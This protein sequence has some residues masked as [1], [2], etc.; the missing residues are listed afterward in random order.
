M[1]TTIAL[2]V[3]LFLACILIGAL[4]GIV[5]LLL[6]PKTRVPTSAVLGTCGM[7]VVL[8]FGGLFMVRMGRQ[9]TSQP[10]RQVGTLPSSKPQPVANGA[11]DENTKTFEALK[12]LW[13]ASTTA[14]EPTKPAAP[15][16]VPKS[17]SPETVPKGEDALSQAAATKTVGI[18]R[19]MVRALGTALAEEE[20]AL[21]A[22]KTATA[23]TVA[24]PPVPTKPAW[25]DAEPSRQGKTYQTT[26]VVGP[27]TTRAECDAKTIEV[28]QEALDR[29]VE[30]AIGP[31]AVGMVELSGDYLRDKVIVDQWEE[32]RSYS[33]GP[34]VRLHLRLEFNGQVKG[35][36]EEAYRDAIV[37]G[38]LRVFGGWSVVALSLLAI[39]FGYLKSDIATGGIY[40]GRLRLTAV[41]VI[42][43]LMAVVA[44]AI[45]V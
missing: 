13:T 7:I 44:V 37:V 20:Q 39:G 21:A 12:Q 24:V 23:P 30:I 22:K 29:Y 16:A 42:L 40:R 3:L 43:V 11:N 25:V 14:K 45:V 5:L 34:M 31:E 38:R 27:Y 8:V 41:A 36:I 17:T 28:V 2:P 6:N 1:A 32:T 9:A 15:A 35:R 33:V 19:A 10:I 26:A 18:L 4:V